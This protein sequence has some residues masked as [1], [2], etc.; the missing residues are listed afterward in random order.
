MI[1][2]T[3]G[4]WREE[5]GIGSVLVGGGVTFTSQKGFWQAQGK[6]Q[7]RKALFKSR[8]SEE[9]KIYAFN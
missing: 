5:E 9:K 8:P 4:E 7:L 2:E 6:K 3:S 1:S